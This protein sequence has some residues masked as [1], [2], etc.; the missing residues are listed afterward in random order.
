MST[1]TIVASDDPIQLLLERPTSSPE[2]LAMAAY[3]L[4][5]YLYLETSNSLQALS[6]IAGYS[7]LFLSKFFKNQKQLDDPRPKILQTWGFI[8]IIGGFSFDKWLDA[9]SIFA[10][11]MMVAEAPTAEV[12]VSLALALRIRGASSIQ[13]SIAQLALIIYNVH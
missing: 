7:C 9:F 11:G 13:M 4:L 12:L 8:F 2:W 10:Y 1:T 3:G 5:I 6:S